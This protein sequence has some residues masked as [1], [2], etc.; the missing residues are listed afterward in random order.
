MSACPPPLFDSGKV[1]GPHA[2]QKLRRARSRWQ[3]LDEA[4]VLE[5]EGD[6][7][8]ASATSLAF[9]P[10]VARTFFELARAL[11]RRSSASPG[12]RAGLPGGRCPPGSSPDRTR[13]AIPH[14]RRRVVREAGRELSTSACTA[15]LASTGRRTRCVYARL[16]D[17]VFL[18]QRLLICLRLRQYRE[19][20]HSRTRGTNSAPLGWCPRLLP[21]A[22][23]AF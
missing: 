9:E 14:H 13:A 5:R 8:R 23:F 10:R 1:P 22:A 21:P 4:E 16:A 6:R 17:A 19:A 11:Q 20:R 3:I 15:R 2:D 12:T 18:S 7:A